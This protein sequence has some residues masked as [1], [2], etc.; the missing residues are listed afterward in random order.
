[1]QITLVTLREGCELLDPW[2]KGTVL[3]GEQGRGHAPVRPQCRP[4][5]KV[6]VK[7]DWN[8]N[9]VT[10]CRLYAKNGLF[11]HMIYSIFR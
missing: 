6:F 2:I 3:R 10:M 9:L 7:C 5:T 8:E 1:M 11:E 4:Q